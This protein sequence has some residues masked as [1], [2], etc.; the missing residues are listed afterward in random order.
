VKTGTLPAI[1]P[2]KKRRRTEA[3]NLHKL[4]AKIQIPKLINGNKINLSLTF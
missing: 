3:L 1:K 4:T 2:N